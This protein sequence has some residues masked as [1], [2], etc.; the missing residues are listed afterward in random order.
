MIVHHGLLF[1][2]TMIIYFR[3]LG[4]SGYAMLTVPINYSLEAIGVIDFIFY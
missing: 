2:E 4:N 1:E 3:F